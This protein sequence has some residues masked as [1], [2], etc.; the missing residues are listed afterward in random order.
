MSWQQIYRGYFKTHIDDKQLADIRLCTQK[1]WALGSECFKE[2]VEK[3]TKRR[4]RPLQRGGKH[5][6]AVLKQEQD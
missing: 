5:K 6:C 2:E 1:G 3:I 4:T